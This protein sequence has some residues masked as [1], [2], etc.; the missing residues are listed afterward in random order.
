[1]KNKYSADITKNLVKKIAISTIIYTLIFIAMWIIASAYCHS[2]IWYPE[3]ELY[4]FLKLI[5]QNVIIEFIVWLIGVII[6]FF[7]HL[8]K[9]L[10]Y[11]DSLVNASIKLVNDDEDYIK[12][13]EELKAIEDRLNIVKKNAV[14]NLKLAIEEEKKKEDLI[15]YLAHDIR[16]PLTVMIGYLELLK[17]SK[18]EIKNKE[19][20]LNITLEKAY[21]L[22]TLIEEL[23]EITKFNLNRIELIKEE[24]NLNLMIEQIIDDFYPVLKEKN[25]K[26]ELESKDKIV[27]KADSI[28][29]ARVFNNII[30]NAIYYSVSDSNIN[31]IIRSNNNYA[32]VDIISKG[33]IKEKDLNK[34][35]EKF[36]RADKA[37]NSVNGGSGLGLF[38]AKEIIKLHEGDI[39]VKVVD[40]KTIFI[41]KLPLN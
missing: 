37:R 28:K 17:D 38:I 16:T 31:I 40:D 11:I 19:K 9:T 5:E 23:F 41:V 20:Y 26:I 30:K 36:Y 22:E 15:I 1:M 3:D 34:I 24:I 35:F 32:Y 27:L 25:K 33:V 21:R 2:V 18:L 14:N 12:L 4:Q 6:I 8:R 13:P 39:L 7:Y 10:S 29:L